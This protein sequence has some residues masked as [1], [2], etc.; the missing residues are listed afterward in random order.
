MEANFGYKCIASIH[1]TARSIHVQGT[2][3]LSA[4]K[5]L[6]QMRRSSFYGKVKWPRVKLACGWFI[7]V[8]PRVFA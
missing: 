6:N 5:L 1:P 4:Q 7:S 3:K 2:H 8:L